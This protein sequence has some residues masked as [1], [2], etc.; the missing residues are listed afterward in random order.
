MRHQTSASFLLLCAALFFSGQP[1]TAQQ[2]GGQQ[3]TCVARVNHLDVVIATGSLGKGNDTAASS[4]RE[5]LQSWPARQWNRARGRPPACDSLTA[6]TFLAQYLEIEETDGYC[7]SDDDE[8]GFLLVPGERNYRGRCRATVCERVNMAVDETIETAGSIAG[9]VT[10]TQRPTSGIA[11]FA[12]SSGAMLLSGNAASVTAALGNVATG[13]TTALS[14][15]AVMT[16][17]A[18]SVVAVGGAVYVCN[19]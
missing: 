9:I 19:D 18:V 8:A 13:V 10:G 11:G 7:L 2:S 1:A 3:D 4:R 16:A 12:H 14:A 15:P 5:R 6:I 17:A